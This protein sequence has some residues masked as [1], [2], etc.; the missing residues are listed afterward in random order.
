ME[1]FKNPE[2][3]SYKL[4]LK[5][6]S[7][8]DARQ[9]NTYVAGIPTV[10]GYGGVHAAQD[11]KIFE[12]IIVTCDVASLYPSL[13]IN[14]G[15]SSRKLINPD[16]FKEIRDRRLEL[17]AIKDKRQQ[18]LK[19][20]INSTYGILK[21]RNSSCFD[22]LMSSNVCVAGQLY[23]IELTARIEDYCE[24]LQLN[25]DGIYLLVKNIDEVK[26]I[27]EIAK[28]WE[29]R[30]NLDLEWDIYEQGKLVQKDVNNYL[31]ID[32]S[33]GTY[34]TKG[35]YVKELSLIDNDLPII[36]TA[37]INFFV[38]NKSVEETINN[39]N[40]LI[41]F[42]KVI[43]LTN[44]YKG[45]VYG[46][47]KK[48]KIDGK[49]KI[50]VD[51]GI[52]LKEKVHRVFASTRETDK[53]IYKVKIEKGQ[54]SYEKVAYTPERCF[55]NNEDINGVEIPDYLDKQYYINLANE[56]IRQF[57]EPEIVKI[58]DIP[59]ILFDCMCK[60]KTFY[61]FLANVNETKITKKILEDYIIADCCNIYGKT[62]K[63]LD[64]KEYFDLLYNKDKFT[65]KN[66]E[67]KITNLDILEIVK[68]NA[69]LGKTGKSYSDF[70]FEKALLEIFNYIKNEDINIYDIMEMQVK[71]FNKVRYVDS[72]A[73]E[74]R[75]FILN[76]RNIIAPNL[77]LYNIKTGEIQYRKI[78]K[79]IFNILPLQ[80]GDIIDVLKSE[81]QYGVKNIGKDENGINII[82]AD[83]SKQYDVITQYEIV[84]RDY[85]S[86]SKTVSSVSE[87]D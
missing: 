19:I 7:N 15:Y 31:L 12:G 3:M 63:L 45:V 70:N 73:N 6:E 37:L 14:E 77:I 21:D 41:D 75:W 59:D 46:E 39:S 86:G 58:D 51:D 64:F 55:I 1:W 8:Q 18:P 53:G 65:V 56:R 47:G 35:A 61:E 42:Q 32:K 67:N 60:S 49:D 27:Q 54:K 34:K 17:K 44:L 79:E 71:K 62:K 81:L 4:P 11:T 5:S 2:N 84:Y 83:I 85:K 76:T 22:P 25:T 36:N 16:K 30:T 50:M 80:D 26:K 9:L 69:I 23:L 66:I 87:D 28:E 68:S 74:N 57:L 78:K 82:A 72:S 40:K 38:H 52:Q 33:N 13:M 10:V 43:K 29:K 20:V 48:V 24:I